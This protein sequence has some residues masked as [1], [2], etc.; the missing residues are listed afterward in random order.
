MSSQPGTLDCQSNSRL[1]LR[2]QIAHGLLYTHNRLNANARQTR[3][4]AAYIYALIELLDAKGLVSP[5]ELEPLRESME[6][7]LVDKHR[8]EGNG[9]AFQDPEQDKYTFAA[10][11]ID[12]AGR[13]HLCKASCC[14][15]PFALSRQDVREGVVHWDLG[16]PYLIEHGPDGYCTHMERGSCACTIYAHRPVPCRGYDCRQD[17]R[18]WLDFD[19]MIP[20]S[21][22]EQPDWPYCLAEAETGGQPCSMT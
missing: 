18:I 11:E 4:A 16:Q 22:I 5:A 10:A 19:R 17:R 13:V 21:Q 2:R 3:E 15:L 12:C 1:D 6:Q 20:N 8:H 7:T 14:R 9:V